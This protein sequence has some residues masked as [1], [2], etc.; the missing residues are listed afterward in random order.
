M[1]IHAWAL[2]RLM[3]TPVFRIFTGSIIRQWEIGQKNSA[4]GPPR[5]L[6]TFLSPPACLR[7]RFLSPALH[8]S[9]AQQC[10]FSPGH[11]MRNGCVLCRQ[12]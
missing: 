10:M 2:V 8:W 5:E 3:V 7:R 11:A 9:A 1:R 12:I 6:L 4:G